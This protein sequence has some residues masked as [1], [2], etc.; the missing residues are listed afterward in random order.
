MSKH[1]CCEIEC[2]A[3]A[4]WEIWSGEGPDAFTEACDEHVGVLLSD[5]PMHTVYPIRENDIISDEGMDLI[6]TDPQNQP[7]QFG[8]TPA[9]VEKCQ[10]R[11][12][13]GYIA[14]QTHAAEHMAVGDKQVYC[15]LCRRWQW[16]DELCQWAV[17]DGAMK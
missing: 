12:G 2:G 10:A 15:V 8:V 1:L 4:R 3:P 16:P 5:A 17:V 9:Q 13:R 7:N 6:L 11:R 14:S